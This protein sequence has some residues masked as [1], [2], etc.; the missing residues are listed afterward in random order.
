M[1]SNKALQKGIQTAMQFVCRWALALYGLTP[2]FYYH[3]GKVN[4][5]VEYIYIHQKHREF[6]NE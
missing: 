6:N 1:H 4:S 5:K 3:F 2:K